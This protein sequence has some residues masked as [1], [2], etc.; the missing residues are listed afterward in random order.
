VETDH[1]V[2]YVKP[3]LV[4][5]IRFATWTKSKR[6]RKPAIFI[7]WRKDKKSKEVTVEKIV[8]PPKQKRKE[9]EQSDSKEKFISNW[10][11][12]LSIPVTQKD[13]IEIEGKKVE[14][15]NIEKKI[16][17]DVTKADLIKY[18]DSVSPYILPHLKDRALSLHIKHIAPAHKGLY[19]KDME[20]HQPEWAEIFSTERKH[21]KR[22]K[23]N[24]IDYLVCND[25]ATLIYLINLGCI[26]INPWTSRTSNYLYPDYVIIDLDPS[27]DDF[28]KAVETARAAKEIF[29]KY[30]L[31]AFPKT[32]GKTGMHLY[33]PCS[34]FTFPQAR[35]IA[36]NI[37]DRIHKLIPEITTT[38]ISVSSRG[39][40][41]YID[42]NQNDEADTVAAPYSVRP[43]RQPTVSTPLEWK[44]IKK[45]LSMLD[46]NIHTIE[47]R[48]KKKGDLFKNVLSKKIQDKNNI[49]LNKL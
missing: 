28:S 14:L 35:S 29:T 10:K 11:T 43:A 1:P 2:H 46:F 25:R 31:T 39:S 20:N 38:N 5:E 15:T 32:S 8:A 12:V 49:Y 9:K 24:I 3:R 37:C 45:G 6:I 47:A 36:E 13:T 33:L 34:G 41:L 21:K 42:P 7:G 44:E 16:W 18:Y 17:H 23:R 4:A 26:D 30:K 48:L 19:I 22:G 40:K 27:D